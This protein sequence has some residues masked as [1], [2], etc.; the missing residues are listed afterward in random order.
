MAEH[1]AIVVG[2]GVAGLTAARELS[3]RG[4]SVLLLEARDRIGGRIWSPHRL[5]RPLELGGAWVHWLQPHAWAE[6]TRY[7]IALTSSPEAEH[8]I[9][10]LGDGRHEGA[11]AELFGILS[12]ANEL[13]LADARRWFPDPYDPL[14]NPDVLEIDGLSVTDRI[15]ELDLDPD[16]RTLLAQFWALAANGPADKVAYSQAL[17]WAALSAGSWPLF[18]EAAVTLRFRDGSGVL[19]EALAADGTGD[20]RLQAPVK[21]VA[22]TPDAITVTLAGGEE[23]RAAA[24]V[25]ALPLHALREIDMPMSA[26]KRDAI[27][28]GQASSGFKVWIKLRGEHSVFAYAREDWPLQFCTAEFMDD[29]ETTLMAMGVRSGALD[30]ADPAVVAEHVQRLIPDAEI[31]DVAFHD[32]VHDPFARETWAAHG[33]GSLAALPE[34][35]RPEGRLVLAGSDIASGWAGFIDGAIESGMRAARDVEAILAGRP[36]GAAIVS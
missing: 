36:S 33:P 9:W 19:V 4:H 20:V 10:Y 5:G 17:R 12:A 18:V 21:A 29:G 16:V 26:A 13:L 6:C 1:D 14:A 24:V 31:L 8:A 27:A 2:A 28:R 34:L 11:P 7:G 25:V 35:Q 15:A 3:Q 23:H 32:W 30:A 22:Q